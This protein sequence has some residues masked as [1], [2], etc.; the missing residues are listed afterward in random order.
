MQCQ[1]TKQKGDDAVLC[2]QCQSRDQVC[3]YRG[4]STIVK[5]LEV[6]ESTAW[7]LNEDLD[8]NAARDRMRDLKASHAALQPGTIDELCM[9]LWSLG[10]ADDLMGE[11]G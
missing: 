3:F 10:K 2:A 7:V 5:W 1:T 6:H 11:V 4:V 9:S 8:R